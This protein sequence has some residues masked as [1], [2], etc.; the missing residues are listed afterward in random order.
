MIHSYIF[1]FQSD[2]IQSVA[3]RFFINK[4]SIYLY[5]SDQVRNTTE[6]HGHKKLGGMSKE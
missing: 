3:A 2:V 4:L 5:L 6:F 1:Y